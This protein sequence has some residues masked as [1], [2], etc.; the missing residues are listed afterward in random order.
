MEHVQR[1]LSLTIQAKGGPGNE[2][3]TNIRTTLGRPRVSFGG[4]ETK[5]IQRFKSVQINQGIESG[6]LWIETEFLPT[7]P[8]TTS[9]RTIDQ[10]GPKAMRTA[11][12]TTTAK[13]KSKYNN[14]TLDC[15][16]MNSFTF[17]LLQLK[18]EKTFF[19]VLGTTRT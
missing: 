16:K 8:P 13:N 15:I 7:A 9:R 2:Q 14:C 12:P 6:T 4:K 5:T 11:T 10:Q 18:L 3:Q 17:L 19:R 1:H